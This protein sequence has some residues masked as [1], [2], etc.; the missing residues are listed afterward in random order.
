MT[1]REEIMKAFD[2]YDNGTITRSAFAT[3]VEHETKR[4]YD[5]GY[6]DR[7]NEDEDEYE[8]ELELEDQDDEDNDA[9]L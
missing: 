5:A 8:Y 4:A 9:P 7:D 6:N 1:V 3:V 2:Q